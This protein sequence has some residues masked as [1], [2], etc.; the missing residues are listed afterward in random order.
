MRRFRKHQL[1]IVIVLL[2]F[3][4]GGLLVWRTLG[5]AGNTP[6]GLSGQDGS[7]TTGDTDEVAGQASA[8]ERSHRGTVDEAIA[9][10]VNSLLQLREGEARM[11][12]LP[13]GVVKMEDYAKIMPDA[14]AT[15]EAPSLLGVITKSAARP[16]IESGLRQQRD[17]PTKMGAADGGLTLQSRGLIAE[18]TI[19]PAPDEVSRVKVKCL[20]KGTDTKPGSSLESM[21]SMPP[22]SC[23]LVVSSGPEPEAIL[24]ILGGGMGKG[25]GVQEQK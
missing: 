24:V 5:E 9:A 11:V 21:L 7:A 14:D 18:A 22:G 8:R 6:A 13:A 17:L 19:T 4:G 3:L 2:L 1:W 15:R 23:L 12:S 10:K 16:L 25:S 20:E